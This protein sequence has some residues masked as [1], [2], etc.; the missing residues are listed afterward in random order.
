MIHPRWTIAIGFASAITVLYFWLTMFV[1]VAWLRQRPGDLFAL[2][3]GICLSAALRACCREGVKVVVYIHGAQ[4]GNTDLGH[5]A[6]PLTERMGH[7]LCRA[8]P[9]VEAT[10]SPD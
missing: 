9:G 7:Y 4:C 5:V 10:A 8:H 2:L 6:S 3:I 1:A